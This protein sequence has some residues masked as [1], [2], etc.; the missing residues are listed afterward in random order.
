MNWTV[1]ERTITDVTLD[2]SQIHS[3]DFLAVFR[4]DGLDALI[5]YATGGHAA[6]SA[7]ALWMDDGQ[8]WIVESQGGSYWPKEGI[9]RTLFD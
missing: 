4:L 6:H 7:M 9:Q 5:M 3:G 1:Q 8:L 2:K